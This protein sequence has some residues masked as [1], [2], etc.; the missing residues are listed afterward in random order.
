MT[1][2]RP[3]PLSHNLWQDAAPVLLP[4][5][6]T[7]L[8]FTPIYR[9]QHAPLRHG[10]TPALVDLSIPVVEIRASTPD[11]QGNRSVGL[12]VYGKSRVWERV[13]ETLTPGPDALDAG[14]AMLEKYAASLQA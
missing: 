11:S 14:R 7:T 5:G 10:E 13:D 1:Q 9:V 2:T 12:W 3:F 4:D 6:T 8:H